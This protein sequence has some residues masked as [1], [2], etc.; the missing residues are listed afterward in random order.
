MEALK[1][2]RNRCLE[3]CHARLEDG[4]FG[5]QL[6]LN[7]WPARFKQVKVLQN[8]GAGVGPWNHIQYRFSDSSQD[9]RILI[10][11]NP[12]IFYHFHSLSFVSPQV[13]IPSKHITNPLTKD[14]LRLCFIPYLNSLSELIEKVRVVLPDFDFGINHGA[15][16]DYRHTFLAR[17]EMR[18]QI[19]NSAISQF[20]MPLDKDWDFYCSEQLVEFSTQIDKLNGLIEGGETTTALSAITE[21]MKEF[22]DAPPLLAL[23]AELKYEGE[24]RI[25]ALKHL[26]KSYPNC[27][28]AHSGL[29]LLYHN[30]ENEDKA[31]YHYEK[32]TKLEPQNIINQKTLADFYYVVS[33]RTEEA[34]KLYLKIFTVNPDDIEN[35]LM[36]GHIC[37][38]LKKFD[39]AKVFYDKV[40]EIEPLNMDAKEM[41]E[42]L[43]VRLS[44]TD[45]PVEHLK[46]VPLNQGTKPEFRGLRLNFRV[47]NPEVEDRGASGARVEPAKKIYQDAQALIKS[48]R[49]KD[50]IDTLKRLLEV[51][52]EYASAHNDLG[53]LRY[54]RGNK[55]AALRHYEKAVQLDPGN[56]AFQKNLADFYY[57]EEGRMEEAL[58]IY[59]K[60]LDSNPMDIEILH[61]LGRICESLKKADDA[62][63][64]FNRVL[65]LEPWNMAARERL[66]ELTERQV[67]E[68]RGQKARAGDQWFS[69]TLVES[70]EKMYKDAQELIRHGSDMEGIGALERLLESYPD[71][72]LAHND[73]GAHY[74][75]Q[76]KK[77]KALVHYEHAARIEPYNDT[78]Q[79][80]LADFYYV[81]EGRME[82]ALQIYVKLLHSNPTDIETLLILGQICTSLEKADDASVF[83]KRV[84]ELEPW[85]MDARERS[86]ELEQ[87]EKTEDIQHELQ[88]GWM[89]GW[90]NESEE[91]RRQRTEGGGRDDSAEMLYQ[92]AQK[93]INSDRKKEAVDTLEELVASYPD[94][95]LAHNDLGVLYFHEGDKEKTLEH[96]EKAAELEP[97]NSIFQRNLADFYYVILGRTEE[98]FEIYKKVLEANPDDIE[99]LTISGHISVSLK[100]FDDAE[101]YYGKVLEIEPWNLDIQEKLDQLAK[102]KRVDEDGERSTEDGGQRMEDAAQVMPGESIEAIS[103][104][105][106]SPVVPVFERALQQD[107]RRF[108]ISLIFSSENS[109]RLVRNTIGGKE[110]VGNSDQF[111]IVVDDERECQQK[112]RDIQEI[113]N[114]SK[115]IL[116]VRTGE[117]YSQ[118]AFDAL[119]FVAER[120]NNGRD[121]V[122][123]RAEL[124]AS[125]TSN[126]TV[127][128][129]RSL[130]DRFVMLFEN[131]SNTLKSLAEP[132]GISAMPAQKPAPKKEKREK[133]KVNE[134]AEKTNDASKPSVL[135]RIVKMKDEEGLGWKEIAETFNSEGLPTFSGKGQ[136]HRKTIYKMYHKTTH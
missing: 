7:D 47:H 67:L 39:N 70:P 116:Y 130:T 78:F 63:T 61:I 31:L 36:L 97:G 99:S 71:F 51:Y 66:D 15:A 3:W 12:L 19:E 35:L 123:V 133:K 82:E 52:P 118:D 40:L 117:D 46:A 22:P 87:K 122:S 127:S 92:K 136:W 16:I 59:V 102:A 84:L 57:V 24:E 2:W 119:S 49:D 64:F 11:D 8:I 27:A 101:T 86:A 13:V 134:S 128:V 73:L 4:K 106:S 17:N 107:R 43:A 95:T 68:A 77:E 34:L 110:T 54:N 53:V 23:Q 9:S 44:T 42:Q 55:D 113:Q 109:D 79:K 120:F 5:D 20:K 14:I 10:N 115:N 72:G 98:A 58:R 129:D 111:E 1:W 124:A 112:E 41:V 83:F 105:M 6:Y 21:A 121:A 125:S 93:L 114:S 103:E 29:G 25:K 50:G 37:V 100:K 135:N 28:R 76:G 26:L 30:K 88:D 81:E 65:E 85:N 91:D 131:L 108:V 33:G 126:D 69:D 62:R 96:Y 132:S 56:V 18:S 48:G 80:N 32:A 89:N 45:C 38:H 94:H 90:G 74:F 104:E 60:L 75:N